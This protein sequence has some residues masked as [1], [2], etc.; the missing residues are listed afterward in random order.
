MGDPK[1]TRKKYK[2][3]SHPWEKDRIEE[4]IS[5]KKQ[6]GL[7][8][9]KEIWRINSKL[10]G[11]KD[12]V[13]KLNAMFGE[14]AEKEKDQLR[15]KLLSLGV[16]KP[17][18]TFDDVLGLQTRDLMER[19][20]QTILYKKRLARSIQ[21]A[22]QFIIHRHIMVGN[23][24]ITVPSY[25]VKVREEDLITF[26]ERSELSDPTHPERYEEMPKKEKKKEKKT[27]DKEE[28]V[29]A[30]EDVPEDEEDM[31]KKDLEK[32]KKEEKD[33]EDKK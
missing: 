7:K 30:F 26:D 22:R 15:K 18:M 31:I 6:Y 10:K 20:L 9:K 17:G 28:D 12:Q 21:Q 2:N 32:G 13:K 24:K 25:L 29:A 14:Q 19:R 33:E 16:I 3:P 27:K 4:E 11:F 23:K 1:K 5:L 8:N